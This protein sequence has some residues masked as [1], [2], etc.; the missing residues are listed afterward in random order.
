MKIV[1]LLI[2]LLFSAIDLSAQLVNDFR[3]NDDTVASGDYGGRIDTDAEGNYVIVWNH[4]YLNVTNI[5]CQLFDKFSKKIGNNFRIN[6]LPDTSSAP[7]IAVFRTGKF[8]VCWR[9]RTFSGAGIIFK[10]F[11]KNGNSVANEILISDSS[12]GSFGKPFI[13]VNSRGEYIVTWE[14]RPNFQSNEIVYY[15]MIDSLGNKIGTNRIADDTTSRK[16]NPSINVFPDNRF[17][18]MWQDQRPPAAPSFDD[19]YYQMFDESGNKIG[20][21][22]KINDDTISMD[23][24]L[25]PLGASD[26]LNRYCICFTNLN[27][28]T[29]QS[30]VTCQLY[31]SDGTKNG[32]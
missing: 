29:I 15:Q 13:G 5:Y 12:S 19:V 20:V 26:S 25:Y 9:G 8:G 16:T 7:D 6:E 28:S 3:V 1:L 2:L 4:L 22:E 31:N 21:N 23:Q 14:H 24:Q 27:F 10:I 18:I 11:D 30:D 17:I 32:W